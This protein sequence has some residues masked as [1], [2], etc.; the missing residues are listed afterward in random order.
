M[1]RYY[2]LSKKIANALLVF[3]ESAQGCTV[4]LLLFLTLFTSGCANLQTALL[5]PQTYHFRETRWGTSKASVMA[6]EQGKR[7]HF[8]NGN[9]LVFKHRHKGFPILLIYCFRKSQLRTA[10]YL[11]AN[12]A[13]LKDPT[14]LFQQELLKALGEPTQTF[15]DGGILWKRNE[16]LTYTNTYPAVDSDIHDIEDIRARMGLKSKGVSTRVDIKANRFENWHVV[17]AYIDA[18][19]YREL[20]T[21]GLSLSTLEAL[22]PYEEIM[23]GIFRETLE[24]D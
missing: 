18:N 22:S 3:P 12:P 16:T 6:A 13:T 17:C 23:F 1:K 7:V 5:T 2:G 9:T 14:R 10:G 15:K 4:L 24:K 20:N 21:E 8:D 19:F 11:T